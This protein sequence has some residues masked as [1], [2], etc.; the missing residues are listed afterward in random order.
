MATQT[1]TSKYNFTADAIVAV[2]DEQ[3]MSWPQVAKALGLGSPGT[4]RRAYTALVRPHTESV[5]TRTTTRTA[6]VTPVDL[7]GM[8][9]AELRDTLVG[10]TLVVDRGD[11]RTDRTERIAC[12][13]VTSLKDGTINFNDGSKRRSVKATAVVALAK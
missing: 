5:L 10:R 9:L 4:A 1:T 8:K 13:K 2:R 12:A 6:A 7:A 3:Q 11:D